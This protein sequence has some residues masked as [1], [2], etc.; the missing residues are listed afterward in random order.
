MGVRSLYAAA[1]MG[2]MVGGFGCGEPSGPPASE[3]GPESGA[4]PWTDGQPL[5]APCCP[6][7]EAPCRTGLICN[8]RNPL[9]E[10]FICLPLGSRPSG[11][12]CT[13]NRVCRSGSCDVERAQCRA[14]TGEA[15]ELELG[16]AAPQAFCFARDG[17]FVCAPTDGEL[18]SPCRGNFECGEDRVCIDFDGPYRR[19]LEPADAGD[20][21]ADDRQCTQ[22]RFR[23]RP[24]MGLFTCRLGDVDEPCDQSDACRSGVCDG[25]RC[26]PGP[27]GQPCQFD[28]DCEDQLCIESLC[29]PPQREGGPCGDD[30]ECREGLQCEARSCVDP[31]PMCIPGAGA[32]PQGR[33]CQIVRL[34]R[35][36]E[37]DEYECR[38]DGQTARDGSCRTEPCRAGL[39]CVDFGGGPRCELP[40][41]GSMDCTVR[42]QCVPLEF[43]GRSVGF[44][45]CVNR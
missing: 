4:C 6:G 16:C 18:G 34:A 38:I 30:D 14:A 17:G 19:C 40:C 10:D 41:L 23:C 45:V 35:P 15:C 36:P 21:C 29:A 25:G 32:C 9:L 28:G 37:R 26:A 44:G 39:V 3:P 8:P 12:A 7:R 27:G 42:E 2:L 43:D 5:A 11:A 13:D 20:A 31:V 24:T 22:T 1:A 33:S